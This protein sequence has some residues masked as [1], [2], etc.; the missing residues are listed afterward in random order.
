MK[1]I[2]IVTIVDYNYGNRLQ[3]YA[4]QKL[5]QRYGLAPETIRL[6]NR[7]ED[8]FKHLVRDSLKNDRYARFRRFDKHIIWSQYTFEDDYSNEYDFFA[9]GSDQVWNAEWFDRSP[10]RKSN[11]LLSFAKPEQRICISPSFGTTTIPEKWRPWFAEQLNQF[12]KLSVREWQGAD[13]IYNLTGK[14]AEVLIDPTLMLKRSEWLQVACPP[15]KIDTSRPYLLTYF[16]GGRDEK[17]N[18]M[19]KHVSSEYDLQVIHIMDPEM[20]NADIGPSEFLYL[21]ANAQIVMT[22]S[23]HAC[24]F[25]F[26]F[27][28][29]FLVYPRL[30]DGYNMISR[31]ETLLKDFQL[32]RKFS[33]S[34]IKNDL[35]ECAYEP[36]YKRLE[37]ERKRFNKFLMEALNKSL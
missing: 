28:K 23:Y 2:A 12:P 19:V 5:L 22:D 13:M 31:I 27:K 37:K 35:F 25:S 7:W 26:L 3:N 1:K 34:G 9:I 21:F 29:P 33:K 15:R 32:E 8:K 14:S 4:V 6:T 10:Y 18:E 11:Y 20:N 16:L 24:V 30:D 17:E 36:G